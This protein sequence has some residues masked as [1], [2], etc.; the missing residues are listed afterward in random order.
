MLRQDM[1]LAT[2]LLQSTQRRRSHTQW[3]TLM[4]ERRRTETDQGRHGCDRWSSVEPQWR[5]SGAGTEYKAA[6]RA[7]LEGLHLRGRGRHTLGC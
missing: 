1:L 6:G 4:F 7:L 3:I 2:Q 5:S